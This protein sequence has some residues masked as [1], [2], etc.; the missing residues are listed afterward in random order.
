MSSDFNNFPGSYKKLLKFKFND[1]AKHR[2]DYATKKNVAPYDQDDVEKFWKMV[3]DP[4]VNFDPYSNYD[5][6]CEVLV[7]FVNRG[8]ILRGHN[9]PVNL[10][11]SDINF[12]E[13]VNGKKFVELSQLR[14]AKNGTLSMANTSYTQGY[15]NSIPEDEK[16]VYCVYKLID[17]MIKSHLP[18]GHQ[19]K[20]FMQRARMSELFNRK[21][22]GNYREASATVHFKNY[23]FDKYAKSLA[24]KCGFNDAKR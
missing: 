4:D 22:L 21:G 6:L 20:F 11:V 18:E 16:N 17:F 23:T 13:N 24:I 14:G 10:L 3:E 15:E 5:D 2:D 7:F 12:F 1:T 19:G 8:W 9:E